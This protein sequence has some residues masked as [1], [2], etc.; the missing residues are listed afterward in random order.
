MFDYIC[1]QYYVEQKENGHDA[2][3]NAINFG[4]S[5]LNWLQYGE[6]PNHKNFVDEI[7]YNKYS[8][9]TKQLLQKYQTEC[10]I[11]INN[12]ETIYKYTCNEMLSIKLY[13]DTDKLCS[14]FRQSH[15]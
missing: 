7:L 13:T 1:E 12:S 11:K 5:V 4:V 14:I 3:I 9:I 8:T 10:M 15:R 6:T 2:R